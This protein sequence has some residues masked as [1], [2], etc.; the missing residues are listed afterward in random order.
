MATH[1]ATGASES[2]FA[3]F[4]RFSAKFPKYDADDAR[5]TWDSFKPTQIGAG[6]LIYLADEAQP[7]WRE[8]YG[9]KLEAGARE[10]EQGGDQHRGA[11]GREREQGLR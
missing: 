8:E 10:D 6:T 7:G 3:A 11:R 1:A 4:D 2:G 9:A 5:R